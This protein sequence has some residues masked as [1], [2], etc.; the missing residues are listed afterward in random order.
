M[1]SGTSKAS[2]RIADLETQLAAAN[3]RIAA[4]EAAGTVPLSGEQ[5]LPPPSECPLEGASFAG[6]LPKSSQ[7]IQWV[8]LGNHLANLSFYNENVATDA[9]KELYVSYPVRLRKCAGFMRCWGV[10]PKVKDHVRSLIGDQTITAVVPASDERAHDIVGVLVPFADGRTPPGGGRGLLPVP[11]AHLDWL[12]VFEPPSG[13]GEVCVY[14]FSM[15]EDLWPPTLEMPILQS[16]VDTILRGALCHGEDFAAEWLDQIQ[17]WESGPGVC[18]FL[19]DRDSA[20]RPWVSDALAPTYERILAKHPPGEVIR[21]RAYKECYLS[22]AHPQNGVGDRESLPVGVEFVPPAPLAARRAGGGNFLFGFGSIIQTKSRAGSDPKAV[23]AAPCRIKASWGYVREWNFQASTA[24]ICALGLRR[25]RPGE[26]GASINGVLFPGPDD[27]AEFDKRENGYMRVEVPRDQVELLSW[28]ELPPGATISCYVPYAPS[29]VEKY[30]KDP[31]TGYP[32]CSGP[33]R[34]P[35]LL[36]EEEPGLG[37]LPPSADYPILQTYIDV[38]V[39]GC[40]EHGEAFARE[41]IA[42]TFLWS[43]FWLNERELARRPWLHQKQYVKIDA[44]L[45]EG[46]PAYFCHRKL[47]SE[48]AVFLGR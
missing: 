41:F 22:D 11:L 15:V 12:G 6:P 33:G 38:C 8:F 30:G 2:A 4:L 7:P 37:L 39:S 17:W 16:H 48:Y 10:G 21:H 28:H 26:Q 19:N 32:V 20:R 46:V 34:P 31:I 44:L 9:S 45:R 13:V 36:P 42:T 14:S 3:K 1:G 24:Q 43:P 25:V 18:Y 35:G 5:Q 47:E 40:L 29:V 23:D 27:M